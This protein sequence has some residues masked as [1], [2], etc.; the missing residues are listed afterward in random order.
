MVM[1]T[2][3]GPE[4]TITAGQHFVERPQDI[5]MVSRNPSKTAPAR[6][7]VVMIKDQGAPITVAAE[8]S[9]ATD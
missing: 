2:R 4:T 1:K 3:E 7:L 5:H 9:P 8:A 6:F